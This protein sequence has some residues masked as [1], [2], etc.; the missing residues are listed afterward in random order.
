MNEIEKT[1]PKCFISYSWDSNIHQEWVRNL[2]TKLQTSGVLTQLDQWD[3]KPGQDMMEFMEYS[4]RT[5]DFVFL[6]CTP[7]FAE[8]ANAGRGGVGYE[9]SIVTG[10][11]FYSTDQNTKFIPLL[12]EG[13]P[14]ESLPS[15]FKSKVYIDF[16]KE[17]NFDQQFEELI[18][19]I[20]NTPKFPKPEL[21]TKPDFSKPLDT[22]ATKKLVN[23]NF[24]IFTF[25][26]TSYNFKL[27]DWWNDVQFD[28]KEAKIT[29]KNSIDIFVKKKFGADVGTKNTWKFALKAHALYCQKTNRIPVYIAHCASEGQDFELSTKVYT[30]LYNLVDD[31]NS[32]KDWY[33]TYPAYEAADDYQEIGQVGLAISWYKKATEEIN[34]NFEHAIQYYAKKSLK[35][36]ERLSASKT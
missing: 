8:K 24:L 15:F 27:P 11:I 9:K 32:Y 5:S 21:G 25:Y 22:N 26:G 1:S 35:Q 29:P 18:R 4:V 12:I 13:N 33:R 6:I 10:E 31:S 2:A 30:E 34:N 17:L 16:R 3:L 7:N 14:K 23:D 36:I 28:L 19:N 20:Y